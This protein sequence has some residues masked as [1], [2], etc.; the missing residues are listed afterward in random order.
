MGRPL[1]LDPDPVSGLKTISGRTTPGQPDRIC[2]L[3]KKCIRLLSLLV[4]CCMPAAAIGEKLS[5]DVM[6]LAPYGFRTAS[7]ELQGIFVDMLKAIG[8]QAGLDSTQNLYS[9]PRLTQKMSNR[10]YA[11]SIFI[12]L[13]QLDRRFRLVAELPWRINVVV[14]GEPHLNL[15]SV[16]N[17][18]KVRVAVPRGIRF[19]NPLDEPGAF[20][21]FP[22]N[23]YLQSTRMLKRGRVEAMVGTEPSLIYLMRQE[24][25][26]RP[27]TRLVVDTRS[28]ALYCTEE[29]DIHDKLRDAVNRLTANGEFA[30]IIQRY[31]VTPLPVPR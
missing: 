23:G 11:C 30:A 31:E 25:L 1:L 19:D 20:I 12:R 2:W 13:P 21:R 5:F 16:R 17:L 29:L 9:I 7:G 18:Q 6:A 26:I 8:R 24:R 10:Q 4:L 15:K 28:V 14:V 3:A 22:T 27:L